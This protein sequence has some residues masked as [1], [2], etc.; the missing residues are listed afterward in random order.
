MSQKKRA[1]YMP[2]RISEF[3]IL[4]AAI[5]PAKNL[6]SK[7]I[8]WC[9]LL[10]S[11]V[12]VAFA[13]KNQSLNSRYSLYIAEKFLPLIEILATPQLIIQSGINNIS[14]YFFAIEENAKLKLENEFLKKQNMQM[15]ALENENR[16]LK[17]IVNFSFLENRHYI[18]S[19]L[20][21]NVR[22]KAY[23]AIGFKV[24]I[25]KGFAIIDKNGLVGRIS[26]ALENSSRV[27]M[28]NDIES[29][30]PAINLRTGERTIIVGDG[31]NLMKLLYIPEHH[32]MK[33]GDIIY[34]AGDGGILPRNIPIGKVSSVMGEE[35]RIEAVSDLGNVNFVQVVLPK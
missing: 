10:L 6:F 11:L 1:E 25:E 15:I 32:Q 23:L 27:M 33:I 4:S 14:S 22:N 31:S 21:G 13:Q 2:Q 7:H 18:S 5:Y 8:L 34:S 29:R 30:I 24:G 28:I 35:V 26:E 19:Y 9:L 17:S 20:I 16:N 12:F 3:K